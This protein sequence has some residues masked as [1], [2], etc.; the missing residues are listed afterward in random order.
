M[1]KNL[2]ALLILP[3]C[4]GALALGY[5][6]SER[7]TEEYFHP[8][9]ETKTLE[10][11]LAVIGPAPLYYKETTAGQY[12]S[13]NFAQRHKDWKTASEYLSKIIDKEEAGNDLEKQ[14][15]ILAMGSG[16]VNRAI[17]L[18]RK[19]NAN[20]PNNVL[21]ML[22][23]VMDSF[24]RDDYDGAYAKLEAVPD[25]SL[26]GFIT[27]VLKA[28]ARAAQGEF[29]ISDVPLNSLYAYHA[30]LIGQ[31]TNNIDKA[32]TFVEASLKS[33]DVDPNDLLKIADLYASM[34]KDEKALQLYKLI[35]ASG[36]GTA[37]LN[38]RIKDVSDNK[39]PLETN[40]ASTKETTTKDEASLNVPDIQNAQDGA[41]LVFLNMSEILSRDYSDDSAMIFAN[42]ALHLSP[43]ADK[44]HVI[45]GSILTRHERR[46]DAI[47]HFLKVPKDSLYYAGAQMNIADL[48]QDLD[49]H[50][51]AIS[52]LNNLYKTKDDVNA[53]IQIGH[54]HRSAED[55][56]KA[57]DAYNKAA[58]KIGDPIPEEYWHLLYA[59]GMAYEQTD[60]F[61]KAEEDLLKA[62]A[63]QPNHPYLLNYL[64]YSW[65]DQ[66]INLEQSLD[67]IERAA[68][69]KPDDG[70][71]ADS[72]GWVLHQMGR[73]QEAV[74]HLELAVQLEPYDP[75]I[76]DHL[77]DI[78]WK[79][80]RFIEARF[81]WERSY[82]HA[83]DEELKLSLETKIKQG[84]K[85]SEISLQQQAAT[86]EEHITPKK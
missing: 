55:H 51:K 21:A 52:T 50:E 30:L 76:N 56:D 65:A 19:V 43:K 70:Y 68:N 74:P 82:N 62:L 24:S 83:E 6:I 69:L 38:K 54:I 10:D 12:L 44:A 67:M 13:A 77:G 42:M 14:A 58:K 59:R 7:K 53:I 84:L 36:Y 40:D 9:Q 79:V 5:T 11:Y 48:Y 64:G 34:G 75:V 45:L 32:N 78:Y 57:I 46:E 23:L 26:G 8:T 29:N 31:L 85:A 1:N 33:A 16:E 72:L 86:D 63:F 47:E 37:L 80:G 20:Q 35:Q 49:Q 27:P 22:F 4:A 61:E 18:A 28:W 73:T 2:K 41:G 66:G 3:L 17:A 60:Q 25:K 71:I 15:M 39:A 81:Q